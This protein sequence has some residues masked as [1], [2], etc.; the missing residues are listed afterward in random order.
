MNEEA[1]KW[2]PLGPEI[3]KDNSSEEEIEITSE[4]LET[5]KENDSRPNSANSIS[6][7]KRKRKNRDYDWNNKKRK[8]MRKSNTR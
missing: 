2:L 8:I 4:I 3:I 7:K 5:I 1:L 6:K